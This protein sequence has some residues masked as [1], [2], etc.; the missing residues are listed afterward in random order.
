MT[1]TDDGVHLKPILKSDFPVL[2]FKNGIF[3]F[4]KNNFWNINNCFD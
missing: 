3:I 4:I 1:M 2:I